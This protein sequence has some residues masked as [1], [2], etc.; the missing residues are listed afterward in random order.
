MKIITQGNE[1]KIKIKKG[2]DLVYDL[3]S[4]TLGSSGYSVVLDR[5][6]GVP[7]TADDG[8]S[9]AR[10]IEVEDEIENQGVAMIREV[11]QKTNE[12]A[13]DGTTTSIVLAH[14][15][16]EE[17][18]K[19]SENPMLIRQLLEKAKNKVVEELKKV[20]KPLKTDKEILEVATLSANSEELGQ[21]IATVFKA[22][23]RE[24][25]V[26]VEEGKLPETQISTVDGY[27]VERG[28][29]SA[30]MKNK[31]DRAEYTK[32]KVL[33]VG[34]KISSPG[35]IVAILNE[36]IA[37]GIREFV[38]FCPDIDI[39]V[40]NMLLVNRQQGIFNCLVVKASSQNNEVLEDIALVTGATFISKEV[41][42][43]LE[44]I[45]VDN[46]GEAEKITA[47]K[48]K[49]IIINGKGKV[50]EKVRE[51]KVQLLITKN[52]NE[53]DLIEKR[54]GRLT[55]SIAQISVG[56]R[57]ET[58]MR[59][60]YL[61][62]EDAVNS[63]KSALEEGIVEGGGMALYRISKTLSDK[64]LGERI[65]KVALHAPLKKIIENSNRDY[66]DILLNMP[67]DMGYDAKNDIYVDM[68]KAGIVDPVKVERCSIE[69]AVSFAGT[70]LTSKA[71]IA[72]KQEKPKDE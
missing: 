50:K 66:T 46:L 34:D 29:L 68:F 63:V 44:S 39:G 3:I 45:K 60:K 9:I 20:A 32:P 51:L 49:T 6:F 7:L 2:F 1:Y 19:Y 22:V 70:F 42:L 18:L 61:K 5:G 33:V 26:S 13:G 37:K 41:G 38:I 36:M 71:A 23:G 11:A 16:V 57:T 31:E 69:N 8:V 43:T 53:Y 65:M 40:V 14:A 64:D 58:E 55:N 15:L 25:I 52:E 62:V 67:K 27:E 24:G 72:I 10:Q 48:D 4:G 12:Q 47:T 17:G 21:Q 30:Y 59:D 54:I 28:Y 56:A 35:E